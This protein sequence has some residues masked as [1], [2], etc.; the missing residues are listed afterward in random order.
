MVLLHHVVQILRLSNFDRHFAI[1]IDR[2]YPCEIRPALVDRHR[3]RY[4]VSSDRLFE[5]A[6]GRGLVPL[7]AEQEV[8]RVAG[9]IDGPIQVLPFALDQD[10]GPH[11]P[12]STDL[13]LARSECL[14]ERGQ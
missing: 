8:N 4:A 5:I 12:S 3:L 13:F 6:P 1:S 14:T 2:I 11:S 7:G 9:L 10:A